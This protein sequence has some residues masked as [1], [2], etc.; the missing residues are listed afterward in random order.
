MRGGEIRPR[1]VF[2]ENIAAGAKVS[3]ALF[4]YPPCFRRFSTYFHV[5]PGSGT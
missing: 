4:R 5:R 2:L 1:R 3:E